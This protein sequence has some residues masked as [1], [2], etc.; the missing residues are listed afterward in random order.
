MRRR[1]NHVDHITHGRYP[2]WYQPDKGDTESLE[3][4]DLS[5]AWGGG[6]S[7]GESLIGNLW[8][9]GMSLYAALA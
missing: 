8:E 6:G 3:Y 2:S 1:K 7:P 4:D 5:A 9:N